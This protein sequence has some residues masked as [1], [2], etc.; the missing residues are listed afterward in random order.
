MSI[1]HIIALTTLMLAASTL[2]AQESTTTVTL[3]SCRT[4]ALQHQAK[5]KAAR[6][7][8]A[9]AE[10]T[11]KGATTKYFPTLSGSVG[12]FHSQDYLVNINTNEM[13]NSGAQ[14]DVSGTI[15]GQQINSGN[16]IL[17]QVADYL[18]VDLNASLKMLDHG[19]FANLVLTQ[20][21][22]AGGRI[23]TGNRLASLGV[24]A[25]QLQM[26]MTQDEVLMGVEE[27]YWLLHTLYAKLDAIEQAIEMVDTLRRDA[28]AGNDAGVIGKNDLLKVKLKQNELLASRTQ[29]K[30]GI[31]LATQALAQ[32]VG[33]PE[34]ANARLELSAEETPGAIAATVP[35]ASQRVEAQLLDL[36]VRA[37]ELKTRMTI[38]EL[39][40]QVAIGA[41]YGA[42]NLVSDK[43]KANGLVF[44]TASVPIT[45]W[46][47]GTHNIRKQKISK[48]MAEIKKQDLVEQMALQN[49]Q[50]YNEMVESA[51]VLELKKQAV[52]D[53]EEN[54]ADVINFY[55]AGLSSVSELLEAQT[56]R[57]KAL[58]ELADQQAL[59]SLKTCRWRQLCQSTAK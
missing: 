54:L 42:N 7:E 6:L 47:E 20:P 16:P 24:E 53:A 56:L 13:A 32:Y 58:S 59:N 21:I 40:P 8:V 55:Q 35:D 23:A 12:G 45:G 48:Q 41:T 52:K 38:G 31:S 10:E 15:R 2:R 50:A 30:N 29:L 5:M 39:L 33:K 3:D 4:W 19:L 9:A 44:A 28:E 11:K 18:G 37:E 49:Q 14:L 25:A 22:F 1:R 46:W 36:G 26:Q 43:F 57:Q 17:D 34:L 27:R 51:E